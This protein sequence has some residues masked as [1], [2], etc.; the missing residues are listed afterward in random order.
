LYNRPLVTDGHEASSPGHDGP[1]SSPQVATSA[2]NAHSFDRPPLSSG[3]QSPSPSFM[4]ASF[5]YPDG[6]GRPVQLNYATM[7]KDRARQALMQVHEHLSRQFPEA[8]PI[9]LD[10]PQQPENHP[11]PTPAGI[12]KAAAEPNAA[13]TGP[14]AETE[15][16]RS[17]PER[18]EDAVVKAIPED[19]FADDAVYK[20]FKKMRKKLGKKVLS[21]SMT[22]D[23]ARAKLGRQFAQKGADEPQEAVQKSAVV[24]PVSSSLPGAEVVY[25]V[26]GTV[27]PAVIKAAVTEA[28]RAQ[29]VPL[30]AAE[31]KSFDPSPA[32]EAAVTK[33]MT[34]L[35]E[36][37]DAQDK[38]LADNQRVLDAIADQPDPSTAAF[39]GLAFNPV[40]KSAARP[41][42]VPDIA[43]SAARAQDMIRRNLQS[44]Y[45][46]HSSPAVRE[47]AGQELA[48]LGW[49]PSMT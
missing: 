36:R 23:E 11:V 14:D 42:A 1:N 26:S 6:T 41:A 4:K 48:K 45:Y 28:L 34:P 17:L 40:Q 2:P 29:A 44:T 3:H 20:G 27:D 39:S 24:T 21:G 9:S 32:I 12:G 49:E 25:N 19:V 18:P 31:I 8:C 22:V 13:L 30:E 7:E 10:G 38:A 43:E 37:I 16:G 5:E 15:R 46:T 33:A 35:L 47:A